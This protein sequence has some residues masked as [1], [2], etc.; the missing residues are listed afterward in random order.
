MSR[1]CLCVL[2][3]SILTVAFSEAFAA[4]FG[5]D[6]M[7]SMEHFARREYPE[8]IKAYYKFFLRSN[9]AMSISSRQ[10]NL[11]SAFAYFKKCC[12][13]NPSDSNAKL[14]L[15]IVYRLIEN[16]RYA[17]SSLEK[18]LSRHPSLF[19]A[20]FI[21]GELFL[22]MN[23]IDEAKNEFQKLRGNPRAAKLVVLA[24]ILMKRRGIG[25][26]TAVRRAA[27]LRRA[28]R[29][30]DFMENSK[31]EAAF[32]QV[33]REFPDEVEGYRALIDLLV[34]MGRLDDADQ[35]FAALRNVVGKQVCIP[36][37]EARLRY[38]QKRFQDVVTILTPLEEREQTNDYFVFFLAESCFNIGKFDKS[39]V[40]FHRLARNDPENLG[41]ILREA[42]SFEGMGNR[43][44]AA[45]VLK[46]ELNRHSDSGL[47]RMELGSLWERMNRIEDAKAEFQIVAGSD[48][49]F[50]LEA[51][52]KLKHLVA[53]LVEEE[54]QRLSR[55]L[56]EKTRERN[57][58]ATA[59]EIAPA[60]GSQGCDKT[61]SQEVKLFQSI[62]RQQQDLTKRLNRL[63]D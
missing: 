1:C 56:V 5:S 42:A 45:E 31:A 43:A 2:M 27:L 61:A 50:R 60:F 3:I 38:F 63:S 46:R 48:S 20:Q 54:K 17:E 36:L 30:L 29:H 53:K 7:V 40:L 15:S 55:L 33:I 11:L 16:W 10:K 35:M 12:V 57:P 18:I 21:K 28:Y 25:T 24:D 22:A 13:A 4:G 8:G 62:V 39:A 19:V 44:L 52:S 26:N 14:Y 58:V 37:Q 23:R 9:P 32:R 34:A 51:G 6:Y 41:F 47:V 49:P 59:R